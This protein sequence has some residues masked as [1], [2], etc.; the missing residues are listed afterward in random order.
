MSRPEHMVS[1]KSARVI[2]GIISMGV[3]TLA[4]LVF[5][6]LS[7]TIAA[8]V[9]PEAHFGVYFLLLAT[10]YLLEVIGNVGLR[11]SAAKFIAGA[12]TDEER[13]IIVNN[14]MTFRLLTVIAV[15]LL[16]IIGKPLLLFLFPSEL[17]ASLFIFVPVL[18]AVQLTEGTL[19]YIMQGF[20]LFKKMAYVQAFTSALNFGLVLLF[21]LVFRLDVAGFILALV[22][23]LSAAILVRYWMIPT[24]IV[25]AF[26]FRLIREIL[27]FGLPLQGNDFLTY[28]IQRVDILILGMLMSPAAIA[29]LEVAA[30][31]PNY[32]RRVYQTLQSVY[33]PHMSELFGHKQ[34]ADAEQILNNFVRLGAF[35]T[36]F[37]ALVFTLFA[38]EI[39]VLIF[40]D[41]YLPSV[42]ALGLLMIVAAISVI[43]QILDTGFVSAGRPAYLLIVNLVMAIVSVIANVFLIPVFGFMGAVYARLA[44]DIVSNPVSVW[45]LRREKIE[46]HLSGYLK[47]ALFLG[48]CLALYWGVGSELVIFRAGVLLVFVGLC[49]A[50]SVVTP[51]D[52]LTLLNS[53]W[54]P[55]HRPVFE[56]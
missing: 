14:L 56:K 55:A 41:K 46:V 17:L 19:S 10:V 31:I 37:S 1:D 21:L 38:P 35:V 15:S 48:I 23:S 36:M 26:D 11:L 52:L 33:F 44:S 43:S 8:R 34:R 40:S 9:I 12:S 29:Y 20:Q 39:I 16:A 50:F 4:Q 18:F 28:I 3:G 53:M 2:R 6:F 24:P 13:R 30:K 27:K 51:A 32:F 45:C 7:V 25:F 47:P 49:L 5:G 42:P 22:L 54:I